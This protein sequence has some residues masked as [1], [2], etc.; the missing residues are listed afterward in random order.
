VV[1]RGSRPD[2]IAMLDSTTT[3]HQRRG[4]PAAR[5]KP[6]LWYMFTFAGSLMFDSP[7]A[8]HAI[9][10]TGSM[11]PLTGVAATTSSM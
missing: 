8:T 2:E 10:V 11:R 3:N 7:P 4:R 6:V 1:R 5:R 9:F